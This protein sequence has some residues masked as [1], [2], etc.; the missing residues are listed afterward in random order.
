[1]CLKETTYSY[2]FLFKT[3]G[4]NFLNC[5]Q[6]FSPV[7]R[8]SVFEW[9]VYVKRSSLDYPWHTYHTCPVQITLLWV[10]FELYQPEPDKDHYW[11][12]SC[13]RRNKHKVRQRLVLLVVRSPFCSSVKACVTGSEKTW[14]WHTT[15]FWNHVQQQVLNKICGLNLPLF[16]FKCGHMKNVAGLVIKHL[17]FDRKLHVCMFG[18]PGTGNLFVVKFEGNCVAPLFITSF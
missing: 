13:I 16:A 1:M 11:W 3:K 5:L 12:K 9:K 6:T 4:W 2:L 15:V 7:S 8:I 18:P 17:K 14:F 10:S